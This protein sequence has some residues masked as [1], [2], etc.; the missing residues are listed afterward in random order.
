MQD[1]RA[2]AIALLTAIQRS[3]PLGVFNPRDYWNIFENRLRTAAIQNIDLKPAFEQ[4]KRK[5]K[6]EQFR[7]DDLESITEVLEGDMDIEVLEQM[8]QF[9]ALLVAHVRIAQQQRKE[10]YDEEKEGDWHIAF[11]APNE[12]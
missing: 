10:A 1:A 7:T 6:I 4:M 3:I 9:P 12:I 2:A 5:L 11:P 8:R